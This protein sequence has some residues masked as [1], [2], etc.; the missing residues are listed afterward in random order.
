MVDPRI[1]PT[2]LQPGDVITSDPRRDFHVRT[3]TVDDF[4]DVVINDHAPDRIRIDR[5]QT[6]TITPRTA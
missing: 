3:V 6:V 5:E 2:E 4:G 1:F